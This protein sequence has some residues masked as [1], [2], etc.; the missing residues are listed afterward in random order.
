MRTKAGKLHMFVG[1][2]RTSK[3]AFVELH[4]EA[5]RRIAAEFLGRL[6]KAIPYKVHTILTDNVLRW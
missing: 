6:I 4:P 5:T 3:F 1:I 2:D